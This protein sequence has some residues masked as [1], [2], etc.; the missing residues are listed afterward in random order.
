[1]EPVR[2]TPSPQ[3]PVSFLSP[4]APPPLSLA[5]ARRGARQD[6]EGDE[7]QGPRSFFNPALEREF[8]GCRSFDSVVSLIRMKGGVYLKSSFGPNDDRVLPFLHTVESEWTMRGDK[9]KK[10]V[11][12][13]YESHPKFSDGAWVYDSH[14]ILS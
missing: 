8:A 11:V 5:E 10:R 12:L 6:S 3:E 2:E 7:N 9:T 4:P 1:M 14:F 13:R